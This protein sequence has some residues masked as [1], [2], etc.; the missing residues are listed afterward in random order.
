MPAI[1]RDT[2]NCCDVRPFDCSASIFSD[3]FRTHQYFERIQDTQQNACFVHIIDIFLKNRGA[4][5][6]LADESEPSHNLIIDVMACPIH[7]SDFSCPE[8]KVTLVE[9]LRP[10]LARWTDTIV[11]RKGLE[12]GGTLTLNDMRYSTEKFDR[13]RKSAYIRR[14]YST[15]A[16]SSEGVRYCWPVALSLRVGLPGVWRHLVDLLGSEGPGSS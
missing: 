7:R 15:T 6:F 2:F 9:A 11:G 13:N 14:A 8:L 1:S 4:A 5:Q 16:F 12:G 3:L 10:V